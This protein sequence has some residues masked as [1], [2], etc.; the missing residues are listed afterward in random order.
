M[1]DLFQCDI[2]GADSILLNCAGNGKGQQQLPDNVGMI[3]FTFICTYIYTHTYIHT[4]T[5]GYLHAS[6]A[7]RIRTGS[8][9]IALNQKVRQNQK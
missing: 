6:V 2:L 1:D 8:A 3:N 9:A 5:Y 7:V 4:Y